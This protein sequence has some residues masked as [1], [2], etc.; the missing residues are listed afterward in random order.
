MRKGELSAPDLALLRTRTDAV[1]D[2]AHPVKLYTHN[3]DVDRINAVELAKLPG[4]DYL[5]TAH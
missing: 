3:V 1:L 2:H 5:F 4:E